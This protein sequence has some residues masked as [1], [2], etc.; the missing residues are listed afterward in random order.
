LSDFFMSAPYQFW[1][2]A[3][4][5]VASEIVPFVAARFQR[6]LRPV[7]MSVCFSF[8]I[9]LVFDIGPAVAVQTIAV[10]GA[11][12]RLR[13]NVLRI[14]A[15]CFRLDASLAVAGLVLHATAH[16]HFSLSEPITGTKL[17]AVL[18]AVGG[19][20]AV[21]YLVQLL[22]A[23]A[24]QGSKWRQAL[25]HLLP[26]DVLSNAA[27]L[28]L[29]PSLISSPSW[30]IAL[31]VVPL[32]AVGQMAR[33][34]GE[35]LRQ[36]RIDPVTGLLSRRGFMAD[37]ENFRIDRRGRILG[38]GPSYAVMLLDLDRFKEVNDAFGH[39]VGD[40]LLAEV[41]RRLSGAV[42]PGDLVSRLGGDEFVVIAMGVRKRSD[43]AALADRIRRVL[44]EPTVLSGL[45]VAVGYSIG[46]AL[47]PDDGEDLGTVMRHADNAMYTAKH[48]GGGVAFY[49]G[50][51]A[52][53]PREGLALLSEVRRALDGDTDGDRI[54]LRYQPE[55]RLADRSVVGV[56]AQL[57]FRR[58]TG[59]RVDPDEI[60]RIAQ[61]A[62]G[63]QR[64]TEW[65]VTRALDQLVAWS[66]QGHHV[67]MSVNVSVRDLETTD[68]VDFLAQ[69]VRR[70]A[71]TPE[72]VALTVDE[73]ALMADPDRL[74]EAL[75]IL[76]GNGIALC[77]DGFGTGRASIED[78]RRLPVDGVKIDRA[79]V[80]RMTT[81]PD[82]DA[83]LKAAVNVGRTLELRLVAKGVDSEAT[84][85]LLAAHGCPIG[86]GSYYASAMT[87]E[88]FGSWLDDRDH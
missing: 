61:Y 30:V 44:A 81:D 19:W 49:E 38:I 70:E 65:V 8:A 79:L 68:L 59:E 13:I 37:V 48:R 71:I 21:N 1:I 35:E 62:P 11:W 54:G 77:L 2:F 67:R 9:L 84:H 73:S 42:R 64:L 18:A 3:A 51:T 76:S 80:G 63:M 29:A 26:Y 47:Y 14:L 57:D 56:E 33:M 72:L 25:R 12:L 74:S 87:A 66:H 22:Y 7:F 10:L 4:L 69:R 83:I 16:D 27:L 39:E 46:V 86:Q 88:E 20:F 60:F 32:V 82:S 34:S 23:W 58:S 50:E 31:L 43:A 78:L 75:G 6:L 24:R 53:K 45:S 85:R 17:G 55:V 28:T 52:T 41:G 5:A 36:A 15:I 40:R